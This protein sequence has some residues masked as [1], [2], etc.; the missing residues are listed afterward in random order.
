VAGGRRRS[1]DGAGARG[2]LLTYNGSAMLRPLVDAPHLVTLLGAVLADAEFGSEHNHRHV[3]LRL[4]ATSAV[5][6]AK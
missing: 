2:L 6:L 3:R 5:I 4:A 1:P